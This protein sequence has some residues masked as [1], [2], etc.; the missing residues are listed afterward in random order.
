MHWKDDGLGAA[1]HTGGWAQVP[2]SRA[3]M[4]APSDAPV[5]ITV[6]VAANLV[7]HALTLS[8]PVTLAV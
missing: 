6:V 8:V 1:T 2:Q 4:A 5:T 7:E 3:T